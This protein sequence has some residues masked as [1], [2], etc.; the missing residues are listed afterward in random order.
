MIADSSPFRRFA[1][2]LRVGSTM[3][4]ERVPANHAAPASKLAAAMFAGLCLATVVPD[5]ARAQGSVPIV[6]DAEIEALVRDYARP[7]LQAAGLSKSGIN[8][9]L[10]NDRHFNAF[11]DGRRIF[12][13]TGALAA[14]DTPNEIIG[15]LA[16]ETGHLAGGHQ[17]RLREQLARAQTMA[18]VATLLG[19]GA[20]VAGAATD[21]PE[22]G[23][24]GMGV[25]AGGT[26]LARRGLL[27][28]QRAEE[29]AADRSAVTYLE[30]T[31]QSAKG[32]LTTFQRFQGA[33]ALAGTQL[34]PYQISHPM[35]R[36]RIA[37][38][39]A[40]A[41]ASPYFDA[42]D[43]PNLQLRHDL[44]RAKIAAFSG[45]ASTAAQL[46]RKSPSGMA[47]SYGD[48]I[49]TYLHGNLKSAL[50]KT[51]ALIKAM[52]KNPYFY[53]LRGDVLIKANKPKEAAAAYA[54]A[55][56]LD[57]V[58][59]GLL[60]VSYG[61]ALVAAGDQASLE[62]AVGALK[63]GLDR[64]KENVNGYR[65][66]AQ[67]YGALGEIPEADL[68]TAEGHFYGGVYKDAKIFAARAQQRLKRGSPGWVR[69]QDI[70]NFKIPKKK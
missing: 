64:D 23:R 4:S 5:A 55:V 49:S 37:N 9:I 70:I 34:D 54:K 44:M 63:T 11:V 27:G 31:K 35:P 15:V 29:T 25:A 13:N 20:M 28:Y 51:D 10:V 50:A 14:A 58:K 57:P 21:N 66:L 59:S 6:R 3:T 67:A 19:A 16:H 7:I 40:L 47:A 17:H 1:D 26:E 36:D 18:I 38:L 22:I 65:Y 32:M 46:W 24:T 52:P 62:K 69:A 33:L 60:Q 45:S 56:N 12:I 41:E 43:P 68:A 61:Q 8:I 42:V 30:R 53:E 2:R 39:Q 48:A